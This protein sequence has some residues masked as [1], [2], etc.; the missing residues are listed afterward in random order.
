MLHK[1][2]Q[3]L[4]RHPAWFPLPLAD[5]H[6]DY[7]LFYLERELSELNKSLSDFG[8]PAPAFDWTAQSGLRPVGTYDAGEEAAIAAE[9]IV[10]L[11]P[12][13][14][15]HFDNIVN[16]VLTAPETAQYYLQGPGGTGKT[17]L[18]K[19]ICHH[20]RG[21]GKSVLCAAS[22]GIAAL[23]L[24]DGRTSHNRFAVPILLDDQSICNITK[25]SLRGKAFAEVDLIIWDEVPMQHKYCFEAVH[26]LLCDMRSVPDEILFGGVSVILGGDFS[27]I[28]PVVP[29]GS[30]AQIV[31]SCLQR[32][33]IW[34]KLTLLQLNTNMRVSGGLRDAEFVKWISSLP[35]DQS[36]SP[37]AS[38]PDYIDRQPD[39]QGL[40]KMI[41]SLRLL[42]S[43]TRN[44]DVFTG[45]ALLTTKNGTV[46]EINQAVHKEMPGVERVYFSRNTAVLSDNPEEDAN[47]P[48]EFL[49]ALEPNG[50][51]P[52][53]LALKVGSPIIMLRNINPAIGLCNGTRM[54]VVQMY[55]HSIKVKIMGG[56]WH[57]EQRTIF[58][59]NIS[60][61]E[62]DLPHILKRYQFPV[63]LCFAMTIN[64]SQ[65]QSFSKVGL[66]FR[67]SC[68]SHGQFYV[69]A[70]RTSKVDGLHVLAGG[71]REFAT[72]NVVYPEVLI[73]PII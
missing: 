21:L 54:A 46:S 57:N 37:L 33:W 66:D 3:G 14:K 8:L 15:L 69:A 17:F 43:A 27:Q 26:R 49:N 50:M 44:F 47:M 55:N 48:V 29:R 22:T 36:M 56:Q 59:V 58:K 12:E 7:G 60:S 34:D 51:Q 73:H 53:R 28:L 20:M 39:L 16:A 32:S 24:P 41:Y 30:R 71:D 5:P 38:I 4:A 42:A 9:L 61:E 35:F 2:E 67:S 25:Q 70:S 23:L 64:K 45:T 6:Y 10:Q 1:L 40:I 19:A 72:A 62:R 65:G 31:H 63:R 68:F 18:Y 52:H 11:N 13:Q